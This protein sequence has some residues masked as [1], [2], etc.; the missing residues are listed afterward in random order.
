MIELYRTADCP[1]CAA[2]EA[3]L[4]EM[5]VA[6]RVITVEPGQKHHAPVN[7]VAL[8]A[9]KDGDDLVSGQSEIAQYLRELDK[10]VVAWRR[11]Q[12]DACYIDD[13]GKVC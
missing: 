10:F 3:A 6:H 1:E 4:K 13:D 11:Y 12:S 5:V 8:P 2:I 9:I 7:G